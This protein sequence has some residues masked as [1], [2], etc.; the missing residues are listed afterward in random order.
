MPVLDGLRLSVE[1]SVKCSVI[2]DNKGK[3]Q[4]VGGWSV[5][6][7]G[8]IV[9]TLTTDKVKSFG[10]LLT[11]VA[12]RYVNDAL[13]KHGVVYNYVAQCNV[14]SLRWLKRLGFRAGGEC[15]LSD[16]PFIL[17]YRR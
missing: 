12:M 9:W 6:E 4:A 7:H 3:P 1:S 11:V 5:T 10:K 8:A 15:V 2:E 13:T 17:M 14:T 16:E